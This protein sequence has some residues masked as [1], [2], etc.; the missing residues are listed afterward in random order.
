M[1]WHHGWNVLA[2]AIVF[3]AVVVGIVYSSFSLWVTPWMQEFHTSRA[4]LMTANAGATLAAG[5]LALFAGP[6]M[7]RYPPATGRSPPGRCHW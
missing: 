3:Q 7:A 5:L 2:V 6:A 1:R 4:A